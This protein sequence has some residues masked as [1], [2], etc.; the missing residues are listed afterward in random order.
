MGTDFF[1]M[2]GAFNRIH[3]FASLFIAALAWGL[4]VLVFEGPAKEQFSESNVLPQAITITPPLLFFLFAAFKRFRHL[5]TALWLRL[6]FLSL[7]ALLAI[8]DLI[9]P[10]FMDRYRF[11]HRV[12]V[13]IWLSGTLLLLVWPGPDEK[14]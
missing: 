5:E 11:Y 6:F 7:V 3:Y 10:D 1:K 13:S 9:W 4:M 12:L 8:S 14:D 2:N